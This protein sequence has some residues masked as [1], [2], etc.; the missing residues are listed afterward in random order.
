M[1]IG[2]DYEYVHWRCRYYK[3]SVLAASSR[4]TILPEHGRN[5]KSIAGIVLLPRPNAYHAS[6]PINEPLALTQRPG[7][8]WWWW[9]RRRGASGEESGGTAH[10]AIAGRRS[11]T[12]GAAAESNCVFAYS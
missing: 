8:R 10:E 9:W 7:K 5:S 3:Q 6:E 4:A 12:Y 1:C 11:L 2:G